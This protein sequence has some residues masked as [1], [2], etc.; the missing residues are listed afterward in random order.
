MRDRSPP[1][2]DR[3]PELV[4]VYGT[5]TDP[6]RVEGVLGPAVETP[7]RF[8]GSA[9]LDGLRRVDGRYPTLAPGGSVDGRLLAVDESG[10]E[11][12]DRYEGVDRGLY[13][14]VAVPRE[15]ASAPVWTYVGDPD[16]LRVNV[17][18]PGNGPLRERVRS[19]LSSAEIVRERNE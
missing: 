12:L 11:R 19:A 18:W 3:P 8:V 9:R 7:W 6:T 16:R 14:R 2:S 1:A 17:D 10:L 13:V 15:D 5:L 4:F